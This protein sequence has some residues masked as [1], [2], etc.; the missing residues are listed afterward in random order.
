MLRDHQ[1]TG[2]LLTLRFLGVHIGLKYEMLVV[3]EL[4]GEAK[5][6]K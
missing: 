3:E 5:G 4:L 6:L 1:K 2:G